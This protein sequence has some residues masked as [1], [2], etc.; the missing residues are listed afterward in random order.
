LF[1]AEGKDLLYQ[2]SRATA[3]L[4]D[5]H[6]AEQ[7]RVLC[8]DILARKPCVAQDGA[9]DIAEIVG[10]A[11]CERADGLH[12]LRLAQLLLK[13]RALAFNPLVFGD[14]A[15][16]GDQAGPALEFNRV[17][18]EQ[19]QVLLAVFAPK[20]RFDIAHLALGRQPDHQLAALLRPDPDI[21]V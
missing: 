8:A 20:Q 14:I 13:R 6:Q 10:D 17:Q 7:R 2:V 11:A 19:E 18:R 16:D 5:F 21:E 3:R 1:A 9:D 4:V 15:A 12:F